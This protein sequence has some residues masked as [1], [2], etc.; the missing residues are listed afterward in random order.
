MI[1]QAGNSLELHNGSALIRDTVHYEVP[2]GTVG[3]FFAGWMV[4]PQSRKE[5]SSF[6]RPVGEEVSIKDAE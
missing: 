3:D 5:S 1:Q 2:M 6:L 4:R